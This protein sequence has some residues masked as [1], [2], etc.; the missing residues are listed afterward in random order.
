[1]AVFSDRQ[2]QHP[3]IGVDLDAGKCPALALRLF[4]KRDIP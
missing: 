1:M 2:A 4:N 3:L